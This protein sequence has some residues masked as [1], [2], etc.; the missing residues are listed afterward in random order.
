MTQDE[1]SL[2][3]DRFNSLTTLINAQFIASHER[4]EKIEAQTTKTNGRVTGL[5]MREIKHN[6]NCPMSAKIRKIEDDQL[7]NNAIKKWIVG[8][9]GIGSAIMGMV[10]IIFEIVTK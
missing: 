4:L 8:S 3:D 7:T 5:E 10:W 2:L 6:E 9:V 1:R